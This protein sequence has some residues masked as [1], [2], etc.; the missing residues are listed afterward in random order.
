ML[1]DPAVSR[2]HCRFFLQGASACVEDLGSTSGVKLAGVRLSQ[3]A[4]LDD[5]A[6][7]RL[8]ETEV[9]YQASRGTALARRRG[10]SLTCW[11][12]FSARSSSPAR[13]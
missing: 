3:P 4:V 1:Q 13:R 11:N 8:G 6:I 12:N 9:V 7:L 10:T 5:G 2:Q